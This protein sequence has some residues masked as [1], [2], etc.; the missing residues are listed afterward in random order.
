MMVTA[1]ADSAF[2]AHEQH[3][4]GGGVAN[5]RLSPNE[6]FFGDVEALP[7]LLEDEGVGGLPVGTVEIKGDP[8]LPAPQPVGHRAKHY[9][10]SLTVTRPYPQGPREGD[11]KDARQPQGGK[12]TCI[13]HPCPH[14]VIL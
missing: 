11:E 7:H 3:E 9:C 13:Q 6:A 5:P 14:E 8:A 1:S 4:G 12:A 10:A 2:V